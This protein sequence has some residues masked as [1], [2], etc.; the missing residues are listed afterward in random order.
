[1]ARWILGPGTGNNK[2]VTLP[3]LKVRL[4]LV[5]LAIAILLAFFLGWLRFV[6]P[7]PLPKVAPPPAGFTI[8]DAANGELLAYVTVKVQ[9]GDRLI[10]WDNR[11]FLVFQVEN[12]VAYSR[13]VGVVPP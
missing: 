11:L 13:L 7:G 6:L 2:F 4:F 8:V 3:G 1:M 10:T 12:G 5:A 9:P